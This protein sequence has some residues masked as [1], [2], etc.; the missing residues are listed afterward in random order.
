MTERSYPLRDV[1]KARTRI[2]LYETGLS[3]MKTRRFGEIMVDEICR[4]AETSKVTFFK[5]F[6]QKEALLVYFMRVWLTNRML[7]IE[8]AGKRG[9]GA[10]RHLLDS[11]AT[12]HE[13]VP[14]VMPSLI[15]FLAQTDMHPCM[16]ELGEA[17]VHLLFPGR[18][19]AAAE[20][21]V[22]PALFRRCMLEAQSEGTLA[23]GIEVDDAVKLLWTVFYGAFL[24][25]R[26]YGSS[27]IRG[28]YELHLG[29]LEKS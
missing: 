5:C 17:E 19:E 22:L 26:L 1:K 4:E 8:E 11:V 18:E 25:A 2:R 13:D 6:P 15:A 28:F 29:R 24:T 21:P 16:P 9:F 3:M 10:I 14:G 12:W 7:E 23:P 20:P 27:D